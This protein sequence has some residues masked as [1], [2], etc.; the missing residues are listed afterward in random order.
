MLFNKRVHF[1]LT[2]V[3]ADNNGRYL[4]IVG[5]L[6][7][8]LVLLVNVYAPNFDDPNFIN[9]LFETLPSLNTH[10]LI[11]VIDLNCVMDPA[12]DRSNPRV[13]NPSSMSKAVSEFM[14]CN[15]CIDPWRFYNAQAKVFS[16]F[17]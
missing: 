3:I 17:L 7:Q 5:T 4:I 10:K 6:Y 2:K 13:W 9:R 11:F 12:L 16:F 1:S 15:G 8:N 14:A